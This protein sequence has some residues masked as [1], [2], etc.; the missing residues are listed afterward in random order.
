MTLKAVIDTLDSVDERYHDLYVEKEGKFTLI[1]IEG[2][3]PQVEFD[4]VYRSLSKEREDHKKTK[5]VLQAFDGLEPAAVR[6]KLDRFSELEI[7]AAGK[8]DDKALE[9]LVANRLQAKLAPVER[10]RDRIKAER[11]ALANEVTEYKTTDKRRKISD[12]VT[13]AARTAKVIDT[14][15]EDAV[16]LAERLFEV[17]EAGNVVTKDNVGVTP[18]LTP[19]LWLADMQT[20]RPHWWGPSQGGGAG[21]RNGGGGNLIN[22]FTHDNWNMTEQGKLYRADPAR[23]TKMAEQAGT[24]IGGPKP[25]AK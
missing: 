14:A 18:G 9:T 19:D 23:A 22:P 6:E 7:A 15:H 1:P 21:V 12:K 13:A 8:L 20:K 11:D 25:P 5:T 4:T 16:L 2:M 10:E 17:D 24:K 3:K